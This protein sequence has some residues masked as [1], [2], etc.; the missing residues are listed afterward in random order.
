VRIALFHTSY[1]IHGFQEIYGF[2]EI[3]RNRP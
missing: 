1:G 2:Y 3:A